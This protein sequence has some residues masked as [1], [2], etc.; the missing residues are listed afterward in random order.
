MDHT[1]EGDSKIGQT[2][3]IG[4]GLPEEVRFIMKSCHPGC[5]IR[6]GEQRIMCSENKA[7][8][9]LCFRF[10]AAVILISYQNFQGW[11]GAS[12]I[13]PLLKAVFCL[14]GYSGIFFVVVARKGKAISRFRGL[15]G[16]TT[17]IHP[18][19]YLPQLNSVRSWRGG[20]RSLPTRRCQDAL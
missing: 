3:S 20:C 17:L 18:C 8:T 14:P 13:L 5:R 19:I 16:L 11:S 12:T 7:S 10:T 15:E 2:Q 6:A 4:L 9:W 1:Q